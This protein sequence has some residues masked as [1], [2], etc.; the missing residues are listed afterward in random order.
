MAATPLFTAEMEEQLGYGKYT[1]WLLLSAFRADHL[2]CLLCMI[3]EFDRCSPKILRLFWGDAHKLAGSE[4]S[5][6]ALDALHCLVRGDR[7]DRYAW[8]RNMFAWPRIREAGALPEGERDPGPAKP[9]VFSAAFVE[10][11][12]RDE[13]SRWASSPP[14][15]EQEL[16]CVL[17]LVGEF[18]ARAHTVLP[19]LDS[20]RAEAEGCERARVALHAMH[21][22]VWERERYDVREFDR[23]A[24]LGRAQL[25]FGDLCAPLRAALEKMAP[26]TE[27]NSVCQ[28]GERYELISR[29]RGEKCLEATVTGEGEVVLKRNVG[30]NAVPAAAAAV[31]EMRAPGFH[32]SWAYAW[33]AGNGA[34]RAYEIHHFPRVGKSRRARRFVASPDGASIAELEA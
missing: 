3:G 22:M 34:V 27:W 1:Q 19:L 31:L 29:E 16:Q 26:G 17:W 10:A 25:E 6:L 13:R 21:A 4:R 23:R 11:I 32:K 33:L 5:V 18:S 2:L 30:W 28:L 24:S 20:R 7:F 9:P 12:A 8:A 14:L 15:A